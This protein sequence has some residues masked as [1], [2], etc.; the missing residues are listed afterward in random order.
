MRGQGLE[1]SIV[2]VIER[3]S[4]GTNTQDI[5]TVRKRAG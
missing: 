2:E 1:M 4:V 5:D 3:K